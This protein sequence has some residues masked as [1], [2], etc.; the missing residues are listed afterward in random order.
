MYF[1]EETAIIDG[2]VGTD[3]Q[4]FKNI[5]DALEY[6]TNKSGYEKVYPTRWLLFTWYKGDYTA[7]TLLVE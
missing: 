6:V 3:R 7:T 4:E 1:V 2:W 5:D